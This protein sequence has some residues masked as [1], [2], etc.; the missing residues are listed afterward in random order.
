[1]ADTLR[2]VGAFAPATQYAVPA[3]KRSTPFGFLSDTLLLIIDYY[4]TRKIL[5]KM[6]MNLNETART[7]SDMTWVL[8][9]QVIKS[10]LN[11]ETYPRFQAKLE[12]ITSLLSPKGVLDLQLKTQSLLR[13]QQCLRDTEYITDLSRFVVF[14]HIRHHL[15]NMEFGEA[16][17]Q[18]ELVVPKQPT[19]CN[20]VLSIIALQ[21]DMWKSPPNKDLYL[22]SLSGAFNRMHSTESEFSIQDQSASEWISK[23]S[24]EVFNYL[25]SI[26]DDDLQEFNYLHRNFGHTVRT[27]LNRYISR[28]RE[29]ASIDFIYAMTIIRD[30]YL[31]LS[32]IK[33][34]MLHLWLFSD[35]DTSTPIFNAIDYPELNR[36]LF[37][38]L[39][40]QGY[41]CNESN[42]TPIFKYDIYHF[43]GATEE[44]MFE[45]KQKLHENCKS[46]CFLS[47]VNRLPQFIRA[48]MLETAFPTAKKTIDYYHRCK[49]EQEKT[50]YGY[51]MGSRDNLELF[52]AHETKKL[53]FM[54]DKVNDLIAH[55]D[56]GFDVSETISSF[57]IMFRAISLLGSKSKQQAAARIVEQILAAICFFV[58]GMRMKTNKDVSIMLVGILA[59]YQ[60]VSSNL[61]AIEKGL[62]NLINYMIQ[63]H[64]NYI[65]K[66][67]RAAEQI[68]SADPVIVAQ[69]LAATAE[70][71]NTPM[72]DEQ[73]SYTFLSLAGVI[74]RMF[75]K[76]DDNIA[77]IDGNKLRDFKNCFSAMKSMK[78]IF[79]GL[80]SAFQWVMK[81]LYELWNGVPFEFR[82]SE[83]LHN[84]MK[85]WHEKALVFANDVTIQDKIMNNHE[86]R[87]EIIEHVKLAEEIAVVIMMKNLREPCRAFFD[88]K[89]KFG[90]MMNPLL[91]SAAI[92]AGTD[93]PLYIELCGG[94]GSGKSSLANAIVKAIVQICEKKQFD[95][96]MIY[97]RS[98]YS[99]YW[100]NYN[101]QFACI[102]DD[103][104]QEF[105]EEATTRT[106]A[107]VISMKSPVP[108]FPENPIAELKGVIAFMSKLLISTTNVYS[109]PNLAK[110]ADKGAFER[111]RD[112]YLEVQMKPESY[113]IEGGRRVMNTKS[114]FDPSVYMFKLLDPQGNY[115]DDKI[116]N[117]VEIISYIADAYMAQKAKNESYSQSMDD[118]DFN[119]LMQ[120]EM[121]TEY[122]WDDTLKAK[123]VGPTTA[124]KRESR[125]RYEKDFVTK[126]NFP[127][128][129]PRERYKSVIADVISGD[130]TISELDTIPLMA[131]GSEDFVPQPRNG[132]PGVLK[133]IDL[134]G[135]YENFNNNKGKISGII[136]ETN[137]TYNSWANF[138]PMILG[139]YESVFS[140]LRGSRTVETIG[141]RDE[142]EAAKIKLFQSWRDGILGDE[143]FANFLQDLSEKKMAF[144]WDANK[145]TVRRFL[146]LLER[147]LS[148]EENY[149]LW[150]E[151][152]EFWFVYNQELTTNLKSAEQTLENVKAQK[153]QFTYLQTLRHSFARISASTLV[154]IGTMATYL[155]CKNITVIDV[156]LT[157]MGI[158]VLQGTFMWLWN[159]IS[160]TKTEDES[161]KPFDIDA[162]S[163]VGSYDSEKGVTGGFKPQ[164]GKITIN[165][166]LE[167]Q[168]ATASLGIKDILSKNHVLL[169]YFD[170]K[171]KWS[172]RGIVVKKNRI[173]TV[174]HMLSLP[175]T[176]LKIT[177]SKGVFETTLSDLS[178]QKYAKRD[179]ALIDV[180]LPGFEFR[181]VSKHFVK[182]SDL[183]NIQEDRISILYSE[184]P[185]SAD[186]IHS[187]RP[188]VISVASYKFQQGI[189]HSDN[190]L[191]ISAPVKNGYCGSAYVAMNDSRQRKICGIHICGDEA[192]EIAGG[193][194]LTQEDFN[195]HELPMELAAHGRRTLETRDVTGIL[196]QVVPKVTVIE[197]ENSHYL[198]S[199][200]SMY[201]SRIVGDNPI[202]PSS[203]A[204]T[205]A[206]N[207]DWKPKKGPSKVRPFD[208]DGVRISPA[209]VGISKIDRPVNKYEDDE[210]IDYIV[211]KTM[212]KFPLRQEV[213]V[214][215]ISRFEADN[216]LRD[217]R[218]MKSINLKKSVGWTENLTY[219]T[220]QEL[221]ERKTPESPI[222]PK[223]GTEAL[224]D[225]RCENLL[226]YD[227]LYEDVI[228]LDCLKVEL[229]KQSKLDKGD[230]RI[231][232]SMPWWHFRAC[233]Q[234]LGSFSANIRASSR[235][236]HVAL[237]IDPTSRVQWQHLYDRMTKFGDVVPLGFDHDKMDSRHPKYLDLKFINYVLDWYRIYESHEDMDGY[238]FDQRQ[239]IRFNLMKI[240]ISCRHTID[241]AV[242]SVYNCNPSGWFLTTEINTIVNLWCYWYA[243]IKTAEQKSINISRQEII[244]KAFFYGLGDDALEAIPSEWKKWLTLMD[245]KD[246]YA[247]WGFILTLSTKVHIDETTPF[248]TLDEVDFLKRRFRFEKD[249]IFA[250]LESDVLYEMPLWVK[251]GTEY[252]NTQTRIN[253][254]VALRESFHHGKE[255]FENFKKKINLCLRE[256]GLLMLP[257]NYNDCLAEYLHIDKVTLFDDEDIYEAQ[258]VYMGHAQMDTE[259]QT[260]THL[261]Q[262]VTTLTKNTDLEG[263]A[264]STPES[265]MSGDLG[266]GANPYLDGDTTTPAMHRFYKLANI[267]WD[268]TQAV[269]ANVTNYSFPGVAFDIPHLIDCFNY[270]QYTRFGIEMEFRLNSTLMHAGALLIAW[271]PCSDSSQASLSFQNIYTA[272]NQNHVILSANT[273]TSVRITIPYVNP[274]EWLDMSE[275]YADGALGGII[276]RVYIYV[277]APLTQ[278]GSTFNPILQVTPMFR[279]VNPELAGHSLRDGPVA[280]GEQTEKSETGL[281]S[282]TTM[283]LS[284]TAS[285][286]LSIPMV[287]PWAAKAQAGLYAAS[288]F[289]SKFG[290]DRPVS[291]KTVER[292]QLTF[293][294]GFGPG[295][296]ITMTNILSFDPAARVANDHKIF[297]DYVD[298]DRF[299]NYKLLPSIVKIGSVNPAT[300]VGS[301]F[302]S[303]PVDP[304]YCPST[305]AGATRTI[306]PTHLSTYASLFREYG[307][308]TNIMF[309]FFTTKFTTARIRIT[310]SPRADDTGAVPDNESGDI[311]SMI[312]DICGDTQVRINVPWLQPK[313]WARVRNICDSAATPMLDSGTNGC[314]KMQLVTPV[315][316]QNMVNPGPL[317]YVIYQSG[318]PDFR[319]QAPRDCTQ[320]MVQVW[321]AQ[322]DSAPIIE[323]DIRAAFRTPFD[324]I[325]PAQVIYREGVTIGQ[326]VGSFT[327]YFHRFTFESLFNGG[328]RPGIIDTYSFL[329]NWNRILQTFQF[330]RGS[331][332]FKS[333][334]SNEENFEYLTVAL[335][336]TEDNTLVTNPD[337]RTLQQSGRALE[338]TSIRNCITW[339]LPFY[340]RDSLISIHN[341]EAVFS[342]YQPGF[343]LNPL[344][345]DPPNIHSLFIAT[346]DDFSFG[347]PR[348]APKVTCDAT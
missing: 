340:E 135:N 219:S 315:V 101:G 296:G 232:S 203:I 185:G 125:P 331:L 214:R 222:T 237:G 216:G 24:H 14:C 242:Y 76:R 49:K 221:F 160:G 212:D 287:G 124:P 109:V 114:A 323:T 64:T 80:I 290:L 113:R 146:S 143:K 215:L 183:E 283:D 293:D 152:K 102:L 321:N 151:I 196:E 141:C 3:V 19:I 156:A 294:E 157:V 107:E 262:E 52:L 172:C 270:Y 65:D 129:K 2:G 336:T 20:D 90:A 201:A 208:K 197:S 25:M 236:G 37:G 55:G 348:A 230:T 239:K 210:L 342:A 282:G 243:C 306:Y 158:L 245:I 265:D 159:R 73:A 272:A 269:G 60:V 225:K 164:V 288:K 334:L 226:D 96:S 298:Y 316:V 66:M 27:Y 136:K 229:Q 175:W 26:D 244:E 115:I 78:E 173:V 301:V 253:C 297:A 300:A 104:F 32:N 41:W 163:G 68:A 111:R 31:H 81:Y 279:L 92:M 247:L 128:P 93:Q 322:G 341:F 260:E 177:T 75:G 258:G 218:L 310:V 228:A 10:I 56:A 332:N 307:G 88:L 304:S 202:C 252:R 241:G 144:F 178:I 34:D 132:K 61:G 317:Y 227:K 33:Q 100:P 15:E 198:G 116:L 120:G 145:H 79:Q 257:I 12:C 188:Q 259:R 299:D 233:R 273:G 48:D 21:S 83:E 249:I 277:L 327:E 234:F 339:N 166:E 5:P 167:S 170:S 318:A 278:Q 326:E 42:Y 266:R 171:T 1:V 40:V 267:S 303:Q 153:A 182:A 319:V 30:Q 309:Y 118:I 285:R 268:G 275:S 47:F 149:D 45:R 305:V 138:Y 50:P 186:W 280:H 345:I 94:P 97:Q 324:P 86:I 209:S 51:L 184:K 223:E 347:W 63:S 169:E 329:G 36:L 154:M 238:T 250:P 207:H 320:E 330:V 343:F 67:K 292:M 8:H 59:S 112:V 72:K 134:P 62:T 103:M 251:K 35:E 333:I 54:L 335:Y 28:W 220:K 131:Q 204:E 291:L 11:G 6:Q 13:K 155:L 140:Y 248:M 150:M 189:F 231:F 4:Y 256:S 302:W 213:P 7:L 162:Q 126:Q 194:I 117:F 195:L 89:A 344:S 16:H 23:L 192:S 286:W 43:K 77:K 274:L 261:P 9:D 70:S 147:E 281:L 235:D 95:R 289:L 271:Q 217:Q 29:A 119:N 211:E 148:E 240:A 206:L 127:K 308:G 276:G 168:G 246:S 71:K 313:Q 295:K 311:V 85:N 46:Y 22:K 39:K 58:A 176:S 82:N 181:D 264:K 44:Q 57:R 325:I 84:K 161:P 224:Y 98:P 255:V 110:L 199:V 122:F 338:A 284:K 108:F 87:K 121:S 17:V 133:V 106:A 187:S 179:I 337:V 69:G 263:V 328:F 91:R 142:L 254:E 200:P 314:I 205:A 346:G 105:T 130:P 38:T 99:D 18:E 193:A 180:N 139:Y 53:D 312:V 137:E 123:F 174:K 165:R 191:R 190:A 74:A